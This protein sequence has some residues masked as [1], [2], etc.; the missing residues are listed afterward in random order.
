MEEIALKEVDLADVK[1]NH[2]DHD[3]SNSISRGNTLPKT[4]H[5]VKGPQ[6]V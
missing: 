1:S 6:S 2:P 4:E 5:T 3:L